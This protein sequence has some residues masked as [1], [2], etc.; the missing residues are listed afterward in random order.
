MYAIVETGGKQYRVKPGDVL[1]IER[2]DG[3]LESEI[4]FD[5]VLAVSDGGGL[6]IGTPIVDGAVVTGK[7]LDHGRRDKIVV[8]KYKRR[9]N[10]RRKRGHRQ[11]FTRVQVEEIQAGNG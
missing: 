4:R 3:E 7:V 11:W 2:V 6:R 9:K 8:F 1:D 5:R 10:Y